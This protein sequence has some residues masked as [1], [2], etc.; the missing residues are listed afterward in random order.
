[1]GP[2]CDR[3]KEFLGSS[4]KAIVAMR[5]ILLEGI[6]AAEN[7]DTPRG[8]DAQSYRMVRPHDR[9]V[10]KGQDWRDAFEEELKAKW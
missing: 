5:R 10:P 7:G 6:T 8:V 4:D 3:S 2:I 1:M 9:M